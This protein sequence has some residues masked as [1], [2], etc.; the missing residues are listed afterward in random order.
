M[1]FTYTRTDLISDINRKVHNKQGLFIDINRTCNETVR[2]VLKETDLRTARRKASLTPNLFGEQYEYA[3][4]TDLKSY[5]IIDV[6]QQAQRADGEFNLVPSQIFRTQKKFSDIAIDDYNGMRLLLIN[7]KLSSKKLVISELD[8]TTSGGG[9]WIATGDA[10]NLEADSDDY[11]KGN[12]SLRFG[13]NAAAGTTAGIK[14][15]A[16]STFDL[17]DYLNGNGALFVFHKI[18][19]ATGL[20][21]ITLKVGNDTSNYYSKTITSKNDGT[22]FSTGWNLL[23]FDMT[24]LTTVGSPSSSSFNYV[25]LILNKETTKVS[26]SYYKFDYLVAMVGQN[27]DI[28]Y[29]TKYGWQSSTGAYKENSTS[30]SDY[31]VADTDEYDLIVAK[32]ITIAKRELN[33]PQADIDDA[34]KIYIDKR[35]DYVMKNPSESKVMSYDYYNF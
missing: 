3:S 30:G 14:N 29:Y 26:E 31:L 9:T 21:S 5:G 20:N 16:L 28:E 11:Y 13:I 34:D 12:G 17:S 15:T 23:R 33:Y 4:P 18:Q 27:A 6:D 7:S 1:T 22:A 25:E 35:K 19:S 8:S 32:A 10:E 24:S 2:E